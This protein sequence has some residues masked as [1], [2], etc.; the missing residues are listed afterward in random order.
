MKI[1]K[2]FFRTEIDLTIDELMRLVE[3]SNE[4]EFIL[5]ILRK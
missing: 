4:L 2:T 5:K 1:V 3:L